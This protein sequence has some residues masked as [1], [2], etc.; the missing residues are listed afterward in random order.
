MEE[1]SRISGLVRFP[2]LVG[3]IYPAFPKILPGQQQ[4]GGFEW[5]GSGSTTLKCET[6]I[7]PKKKYSLVQ[8]KGANLWKYPICSVSPGGTTEWQAPPSETCLTPNPL[9]FRAST[10]PPLISQEF[11]GLSSAWWGITQ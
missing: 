11:P 1:R 7:G 8:L 6:L 10:G 2:E 5:E 9:Q 3:E 4:S